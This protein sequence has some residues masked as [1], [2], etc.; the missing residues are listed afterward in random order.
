MTY[1]YWL[2]LLLWTLCVVWLDAIGIPLLNKYFFQETIWSIMK[3]DIDRLAAGITRVLLAAGILIF[4]VM[5][6]AVQ[7]GGD[8]FSLGM[9]FWLVVFGIY[10]GTNQ[11]LLKDWTWTIVLADVAWGMFLCGT[12]SFVLY[13]VGKRFLGM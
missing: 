3:T 6:P 7:D 2:L 1:Q 9:M 11:A 4:V 13:E 5:S 8:A 12:V 10:E